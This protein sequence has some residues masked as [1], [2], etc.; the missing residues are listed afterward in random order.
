MSGDIKVKLIDILDS[1]LYPETDH[2]LYPETEWSAVQNRPS[3]NNEDNNTVINSPGTIRI[4]GEKMEVSVSDGINISTF[5]MFSDK[6]KNWVKIKAQNS[7]ELEA[8]MNAKIDSFDDLQRY[9][10]NNINNLNNAYLAELAKILKEFVQKETKD[11]KG[12]QKSINLSN[13]PINWSALKGRPFKENL[14]LKSPN[15]GEDLIT[16]KSSVMN[17][18]FGV[19]MRPGTPSG[20]FGGCMIFPAFAIIN[21]NVVGG[22]ASINSA[23]YLDYSNTNG[24]YFHKIENSNLSYYY[25]FLK[26]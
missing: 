16:K 4:E 8:F 21:N 26:H 7:Y 2:Y 3:I 9:I 1:C 22:L 15:S 17:A 18:V 19:Y 12:D 23:Y 10:D 25:G 5:A 24:A 14:E 6:L 11:E 20:S 13:Y